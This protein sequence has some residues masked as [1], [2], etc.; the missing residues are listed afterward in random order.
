MACF[1]V[2]STDIFY[3]VGQTGVDAVVLLGVQTLSWKLDSSLT[4]YSERLVS[5]ASG[6]HVNSN[7]I[8]VICAE[9][10]EN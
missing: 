6:H 9:N 2:K 3:S 10:K 4:R 5:L 7:Y 1:T 8:K